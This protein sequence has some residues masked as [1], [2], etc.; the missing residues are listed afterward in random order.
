[1]FVNAS[2]SSCCS[3]ILRYFR[4][5][6]VCEGGLCGYDFVMWMF[7]PLKDLKFVWFPF[8]KWLHLKIS[9][10]TGSLSEAFNKIPTQFQKNS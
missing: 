2:S 10:F 7:K 5:V 4:D 1:M 6:T 3:R 9:V 8:V